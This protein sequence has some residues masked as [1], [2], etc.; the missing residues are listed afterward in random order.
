MKYFIVDAF[1]DSVFHGNPAAVFVLDTW[2]ADDIM[3]KIAK[4]INLSA[5]AFTV[6]QGD[7]YGLRWFMPGGEIDLCGNATLATFY[8][9]VNFYDTEAQVLGFQTKSGE[10]IVTPGIFP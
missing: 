2:L 5:T 4:E 3:Q 6:K 8:V 1:T 7:T 9:I 10:L